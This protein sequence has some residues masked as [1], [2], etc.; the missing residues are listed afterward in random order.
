MVLKNQLIRLR[1]LAEEIFGATAIRPKFGT[2][3][4]VSI[5]AP[6]LQRVAHN[7][8]AR[9][10]GVKLAGLHGVSLDAIMHANHH[11]D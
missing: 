4:A 10:G 2:F 1:T 8:L 11:V 6:A 9:V 3:H 5:D 7:R